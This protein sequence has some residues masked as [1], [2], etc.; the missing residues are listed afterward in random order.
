[1][2]VDF[3]IRVIWFGGMTIL[4]VEVVDINMR[5]P[6]I[7]E[8]LF[9]PPRFDVF[10]GLQGLL[11]QIYLLR[12]VCRHRGD[13]NVKYRTKKESVSNQR[14]EEESLLKNGISVSLY[15]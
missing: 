15:G 13:S 14:V 8:L 12:V 3:A 2:P 6:G 9:V 4:E 7:F 11:V 5:L 10:D 1:V